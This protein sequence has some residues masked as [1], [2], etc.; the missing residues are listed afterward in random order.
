M[1][2]RVETVPSA[3]AGDSDCLHAR[4]AIV[5]MTWLLASVTAIESVVAQL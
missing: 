3:S 5:L 2:N 1:A 4:P